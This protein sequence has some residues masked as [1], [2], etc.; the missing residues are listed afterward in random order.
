M[1]EASPERKCA[2]CWMWSSTSIDHQWGYCYEKDI[3]AT[4]ATDVC[5]EWEDKA[6]ATIKPRT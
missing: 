2:T 5:E 4:R 6:P 1:P 3:V